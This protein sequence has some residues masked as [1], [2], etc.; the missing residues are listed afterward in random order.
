MNKPKNWE[1]FKQ[2]QEKILWVHICTEDF[3]EVAISI[4]NWWKRRYPEYKMRLVSKNVFEQVK[5]Q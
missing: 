3:A 5:M 4:N 2:D 1:I